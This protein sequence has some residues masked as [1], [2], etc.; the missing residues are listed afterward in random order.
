MSVECSPS[1]ARL[2]RAPKATKVLGY[3]MRNPRLLTG[4]ARIK[5]R[6]CD[7]GCR[8]SLA[9]QCRVTRERRGH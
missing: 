1:D 5:T 8:V 6:P 7:L 2:L 3:S 9:T 4:L